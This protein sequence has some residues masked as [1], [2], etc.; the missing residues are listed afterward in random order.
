MEC[1][2]DRVNIPRLPRY[3]SGRSLRSLGSPLNARLLG[4]RSSFQRCRPGRAFVADRPS[5]PAD[6]WLPKMAPVT[7]RLQKPLRGIPIRRFRLAA[8]MLRSPNMGIASGLAALAFARA[9]RCA[10]SARR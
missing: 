3:R 5:I 1:Q 8:S 10:R 6:G 9:A 2:P 4:D 7:E